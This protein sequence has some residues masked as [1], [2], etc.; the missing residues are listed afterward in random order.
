VCAVFVLFWCLGSLELLGLLGL[1]V[2]TI[3]CL[4]LRV[5]LVSSSVFGLCG[6]LICVRV[7][8]K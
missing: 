7:A 6:P 2:E 5:L 1:G 3:F 8:A 4:L